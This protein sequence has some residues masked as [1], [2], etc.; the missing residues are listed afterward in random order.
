MV[1]EMHAATEP[2][3]EPYDAAFEEEEVQ[4]GSSAG[5]GVQI[6]FAPPGSSGKSIVTMSGAG[7]ELAGSLAQANGN[8]MKKV[9]LGALHDALKGESHVSEAKFAEVLRNLLPG[10]DTPAPEAISGLFRAFDVDGSGAVDEK[11]LI[12]GCQALCSGEETTKLKLAFAC[13]DKDGDGHLDAEELKSLLRG[14]I[15][16]AVQSLHAAIDFASF[17]SDDVDVDAINEEANGA[18]A[19][20]SEGAPEGMVKVELKTKAGTATLL[21]P[22]AAFAS[23][24]LDSSALGLGAFIDALVT[25]AIKKYDSDGN[26]TIEGEEFVLFAKENAFLSAWFGRLVGPDGSKAS[27]KDDFDAS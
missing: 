13:F 15:E 26:G 7:G 1:T 23:D 5:V 9:E 4:L 24:Q 19:L 27:W 3:S 2:S 16:P 18:A 22:K 8:F 11:E 10:A 6:S 25:G 14:T 12:A 17:G 20:S 21:A